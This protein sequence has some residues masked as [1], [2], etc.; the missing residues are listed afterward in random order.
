M[1]HR[2]AISVK[3]S[4]F[5]RFFV[6]FIGCQ[7]YHRSQFKTYWED[8][9]T[10]WSGFLDCTHSTHSTILLKNDIQIYEI[11]PWI[12]QAKWVF[13]PFPVLDNTD[14]QLSII[15]HLNVLCYLLWFSQTLARKI[16]LFNI[17]GGTLKKQRL[18]YFILLSCNFN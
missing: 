10:I 11:S 16:I 13:R 6:I 3:M 18:S 4:D 15:W 17:T 9:A 8:F 5:Y 7:T 12:A 14:R 2:L 1:N